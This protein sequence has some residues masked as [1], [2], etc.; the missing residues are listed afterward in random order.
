M[1]FCSF[2]CGTFGVR[3]V[4]PW[5]SHYCITPPLHFDK[6]SQ[7]HAREEEALVVREVVEEAGEEEEEEEAAAVSLEDQ[8]GQGKQSA[9]R[10]AA[11][12]LPCT[13][14]VSVCRSLH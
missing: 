11:V 1:A 3:I 6:A 5:L 7:R 9:V 13:E 10:G 14:R 2:V 8:S 4:S 12:G